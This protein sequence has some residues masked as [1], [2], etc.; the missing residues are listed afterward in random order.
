MVMGSGIM[1]GINNVYGSGSAA[2]SVLST[3]ATKGCMGAF[4]STIYVRIVDVEKLN[5]IY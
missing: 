5:Q 1:G 4:S 3:P 2:A